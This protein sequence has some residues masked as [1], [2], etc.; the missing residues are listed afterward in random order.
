M[1]SASQ[2]RAKAREMLGGNIFN[3]KWLYPL[4]VCL[5]VNAIT[6]IASMIAIGS[7]LVTGPLSVGSALY[8]LS[9][10]RQQE[11]ATENI[12][13]L[14]TP[15]TKDAGGT[16]VLGLLTTVFVAL[17][18]LLF[19]IPGIVKSFSYA[20]APYIKVDHPEY[21]ATQAI[22]ESR[23]IMNGN[24]MR[25]FALYLSFIGWILVAMLTCGIGML[26]V[27]P[28]MSASVAAFYEEIKAPEAEQPEV[29][30]VNL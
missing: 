1:S 27:Y 30:T 16:I 29:E 11:R 2:L 14:F 13:A 17:W 20:M 8:F 24:K 23:R 19:V 25:L 18:S 10:A 6:G 28:Y 7:L 5:I 15:V 22:T 21:T 4:A 3:P 9:I 12:G 26:W